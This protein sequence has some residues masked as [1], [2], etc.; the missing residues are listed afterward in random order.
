MSG[1]QN[2]FMLSMFI[3]Q[4]NCLDDGLCLLS[5]VFAHLW[6]VNGKLSEERVRRLFLDRVHKQG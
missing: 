6:F 2:I 1:I 3:L 4:W 5:S